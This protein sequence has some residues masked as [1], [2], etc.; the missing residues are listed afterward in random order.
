MAVDMCDADHTSA[1]RNI[2]SPRTLIPT[3]QHRIYAEDERP[4]DFVVVTGVFAIEAAVM[5]TSAEVRRLWINP[6]KGS[7]SSLDGVEQLSL[8]IT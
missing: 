1:H 7:I 2:I 6:P 3:A 4:L 5:Q 8:N